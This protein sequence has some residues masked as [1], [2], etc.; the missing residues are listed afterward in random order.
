MENLVAYRIKNARKLRGLSLQNVADALQVSKQMISKYESGLSMPNSAK[1]IKLSK[2]F[3]LKID[4]FFNS[5]KIELNEVNFRKKSTFSVKKQESLKEQIKICLENYLFIEDC[6][7]INY[8]FENPLKDFKISNT[9]DIIKAVQKLRNDWEIG[10]DPVHN[11]IQLLEDKK[12]KIIERSDVED[13]FDGLATCVDNKYPVIVLNKKFQ[14][15]RKRFSLLHELGH[16]LLNIADNCEIKEED[17]CHKFA[18]EFLLPQNIVISEFGGKREHIL[19][20]ELVSIQEKYGISIKAIVYKLKDVGILNENQHSNFYKRIRFDRKFENE[21]DKTRFKTP[22]Y[23]H[24]FER[25]VYRALA[26]GNISISKASSLLDEN[27]EVV[28]SNYELI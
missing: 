24:R 3:D 13:E 14:V 25:L 15:E 12:I 1:L 8:S 22:E 4:Y 9:E 7:S 28:K 26:Q 10:F 11:L 19:F 6:L 2:L 5:F 20:S 27:I 16:L 21:I 23:S 18:S 17:V